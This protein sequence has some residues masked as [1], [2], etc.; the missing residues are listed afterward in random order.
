M[1]T[2]SVYIHIPTKKQTNKLSLY[3]LYINTFVVYKLFETGIETLR[4]IPIF[5]YQLVTLLPFKPIFIIMH[6][7]IDD[8]NKSP[9]LNLEVR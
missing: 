6:M 4:G 8:Q 3:I 5:C 2:K 7:Y 9:R 1:F